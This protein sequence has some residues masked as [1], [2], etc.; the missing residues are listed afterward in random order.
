MRK[1]FKIRR[2]LL[3]WE[4]VH[5]HVPVGCCQAKSEAIRIAITLGRMQRRMG[6]E[7]EITVFNEAGEVRARRVIRVA[8]V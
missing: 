3:T 5:N 6:D 1:Q 8:R 7:S 4:V 2:R